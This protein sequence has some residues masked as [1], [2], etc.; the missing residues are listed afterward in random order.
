MEAKQAVRNVIAVNLKDKTALHANYMPFIRGGGLYALTDQEFK[1]GDSVILSLKIMSI[2]KKFA[3]PG[4]VVWM[5]P[6][7][8]QGAQ[9][10]GVQ[11]VGR[12]KNNVKLT[13]ESILGELAS[14]PSIYHTY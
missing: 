5:S 3:I 9:G 4:K 6:Q 10:I 12:T 2:A 14:K 8:A 7:Q 1:L 11:F 13:L